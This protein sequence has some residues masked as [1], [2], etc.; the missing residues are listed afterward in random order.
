MPQ[1]ISATE[2]VAPI[3]LPLGSERAAYKRASAVAD[4]I[5]AQLSTVPRMVAVVG[6]V[7]GFRLRFNF[8]TGPADGVLQFAAIADTEVRRAPSQHGVWMEARATIE[9][10]PACAEVLM[11][12]EAAAEFEADQAPMAQPVPLGASI[13]ARVQAVIPVTAPAG[14]PATEAAGRDK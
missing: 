1:T 4:R 11:S 5:V 8:G 3:V 6:D 2:T 9:G 7:N 13:L 10:I 14:A 12:D